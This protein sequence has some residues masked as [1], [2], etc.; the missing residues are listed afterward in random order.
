MSKEIEVIGKNAHTL[1]KLL[2]NIQLRKAAILKEISEFT[3]DNPDL[4]PYFV[5]LIEDYIQAD[6]ESSLI[7]T[8][9]FRCYDAVLSY[10]REVIGELVENLQK[11]TKLAKE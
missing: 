7:T 10:D 11:F 8:E 5:K 9:I 6:Y 1:F 4:D 3:K 2:G